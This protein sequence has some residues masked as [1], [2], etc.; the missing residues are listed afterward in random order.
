MAD[1]NS[2]TK[3]NYFAVTSEE[4]L[5]AI[6]AEIECNDVI[7]INKLEEDGKKLFSLNAEGTFCGITDNEDDMPNWE[8]MCAEFSKILPE[9]ES[10]VIFDVGHEKL[11]EVAGSTTIITKYGYKTKSLEEVANEIIKEMT[12]NSNFGL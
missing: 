10:L 4:K 1:Y 2:F 6:V 9:G 8:E 5:R 7:E 11:N 3:T 12:S